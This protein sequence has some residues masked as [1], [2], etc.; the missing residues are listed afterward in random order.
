MPEWVP[1]PAT[2]L[3]CATAF[4]LG[5]IPFGLIVARIAGGADPR[6]SGSGNIG[7][8]NISRVMG[9]W[10]WGAATFALDL[11][12]GAV[13]VLALEA[14]LFAAIAAS[15]TGAAAGGS[16]PEAVS[17]V[18]AWAVGL[19]AVLGHCYTPWLG[20]RG[21]KGVATGLGA[22]AVLSPWASLAGLVAF[23]L[24]FAAT[25]VGSIS[26]L[27]GI[28]G[29]SVTHL[30]IAPTGAYLWFGAALVLVILVRHEGNLD[31]L[32]ENREKKFG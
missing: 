4:L 22:L 16:A 27:S 25:R 8:T 17:A 6:R 2:W 30:V 18:A 24:V 15:L 14:G 23:G 29:V 26:S 5:S 28:L 10:P 21:G 13:P 31:A 19:C 11:L 12:K 7:A 9:F 3:A 20:F 32:L 1:G